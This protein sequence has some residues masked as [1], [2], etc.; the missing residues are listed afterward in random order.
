MKAWLIFLCCCLCLLARAQDTIWTVS[1]NTL[2]VRV[3]EISDK[4]VRYKNFYNPD[5]VVRTISNGEVLR[6]VYENGKEEARFKRAPTGLPAASKPEKFVIEGRHLVYKRNDITPKMAFKIMMQRDP[7]YNSD[8]LNNMLVNVQGNKT[9][10]VAFIVAAPVCLVGA[11]LLARNNTYGPND[12]PKA[13]KILFTGVGLSAGCFITSMI[14]K[15][16]KNK[17]IRQ[18]AALYNNE[19]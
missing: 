2:L 13:R 14:Y 9:G 6:I 11:V 4:E 16:I 12:Y 18:A 1:Q 10:Q 8:E 7:K 5:G 3:L 15:G 17:H 19:L